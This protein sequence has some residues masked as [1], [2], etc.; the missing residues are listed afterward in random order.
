MKS[1]FKIFNEKKILK[2]G[3]ALMLSVALLS[4]PVFAG[5][6]PSVELDESET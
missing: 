3:T 2:S 4:Q 6:D 5:D 1:G